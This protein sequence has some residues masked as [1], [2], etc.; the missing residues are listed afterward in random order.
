M[1]ARYSD[2]SEYLES[3]VTFDEASKTVFLRT[4]H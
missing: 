1:H 4:H 2:V 3:Y